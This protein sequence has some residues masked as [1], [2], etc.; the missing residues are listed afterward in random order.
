[1]LHASTYVILA[2]GLTA[3]AFA[4]GAAPRTQN[5]AP[6]AAAPA[7][8]KFKMKDIDG[9]EV[10]LSQ[11]AGKVVVMV[12]VASKCGYTPQYTDLEA[13]F[14]KYKD[15]GLVVLGFPANEFGQ[16][17]SGSDSE[18]KEFCTSKYSVTF[19]MFAKV[20]VKG[21]GTC[22]LYKFLTGSDTNPKFAGEIKWNFTKFLIG[23]NGEV[24]A[25]FEPK[26]KPTSDEMTKAIEAEL[27]KK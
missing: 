3:A 24:I 27:A 16:Q 12:N 7:A 13:I 10:D 1:M 18:I 19:P 22:D 25:R 5:A 21:D 17:E 23:R 26:V 20:I 8:L 9:K 6:A 15:Q 4:V 14:N 11:Y 2:L